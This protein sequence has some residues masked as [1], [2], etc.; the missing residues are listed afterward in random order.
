MSRVA[1][2]ALA[3]LLTGSV[4]TQALAQQAQPAQAQPAQPKWSN[5]E[6]TGY[7]VVYDEKDLVKKAAL[8]EKFFVDHPKADP[9]ALTDM[10]RMLLLSYANSGNWAKTLETIERPTLGP[11]LTEEEKKRNTQIGLLAASSLKDNKK[12]VEYAE[13][14][15]KDDPKNLNA[16]VTLSGVLSATMPS[17]NPGKDPHIARTLDITKQALAVPRPQGIADPQWNQIQQQLR[18]T[19]CL[20]LLNQQKYSETIAECQAALKV[21]PK[22]AYAWYWIGLAHRAPF[23][24][25]N[26]KYTDSVKEYNANLTAPQLQLDELRAAMQG[27]EKIASDKLDETLDAFARA[28]VIG[29]DAGTEAHKEMKKLF[30]GTPEDLQKLIDSKK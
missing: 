20:M 3:L 28:V 10:Y 4:A 24:E 22:D 2:W 17:T 15:L 6:Y 14:V 25:L 9:I 11:N 12:T 13:K 23:V 21:N 16:L 29:G 26:K 19:A 30:T 7:R 27:A 8:A 1:Y 18:D 5:E